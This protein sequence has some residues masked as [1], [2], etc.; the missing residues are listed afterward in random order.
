MRRTVLFYK[1]IDGKCPVQEFL[2][3]LSGK[4]A[5]KVLWTLS[6]LE[7]LEIVPAIYFKKLTGT[8]GIWE[9]R[10]K[11]GSNIY[12]IFCFFN[13]HSVVILTHGLVKKSQKTP[14]REIDKA[15][16][17]RKDFLSRRKIK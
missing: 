3:S 11:Y 5:Q 15:E 2:D 14:Q 4:V 8:E 16:S 13:S 1:T 9:C 7:D 17:Y 10:I 12:R 6:L